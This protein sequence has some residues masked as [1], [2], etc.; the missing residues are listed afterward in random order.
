MLTIYLNKDHD[1]EQEE[2]N[3]SDSYVTEI[4]RRPKKQ[5]KKRSYYE[6]EL[7]SLPDY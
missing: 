6:D 1:I 2:S 4:H 7:D 3:E 5:R